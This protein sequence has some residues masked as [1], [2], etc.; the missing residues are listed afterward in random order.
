[1]ARRLDHGYRIRDIKPP[2]GLEF[3]DF[4]EYELTC[5]FEAIFIEHADATAEYYL[6]G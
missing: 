5:A 2:A 6:G 1:M 4:S 3:D